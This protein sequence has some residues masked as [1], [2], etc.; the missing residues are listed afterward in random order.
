[1][2]EYKYKAKRLDNGEWT[3]GSLFAGHNHCAIL[4]GIRFNPEDEHEMTVTGSRVDRDTICRYAGNDIWENDVIQYEDSVG[5]VK[6]GKHG[7]EEY[8][9]YID[10]K[11]GDISLRDDYAYWADNEDVRVIGSLHDIA[12]ALYAMAE[13]EEK[14]GEA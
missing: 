9:F 5:V 10:W 6:Y 3:Q 12:D 14:K 7:H 4:Q 8:G 2:Q 11:M 1:M 13:K